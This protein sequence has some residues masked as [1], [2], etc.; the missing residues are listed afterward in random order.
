MKVR[1]IQYLHQELG[2]EVIAFESSLLDCYLA[3]SMIPDLSPTEIMEHIFFSDIW[4]TEE[5][6]PLFEYIKDTSSSHSPLILTGFDIFSSGEGLEDGS[7]F[8]FSL[9]EGLDDHYASEIKTLEEIFESSSSLEEF[10]NKINT[11]IGFHESIQAYDELASYIAQ[12]QQ[13]LRQEN[14][15]I[16][17]LVEVADQFAWS[18]ARSIEMIDNRASFDDWG[19]SLKDRDTAMAVNIQFLADELYPDK[20]IIVWAHNGHIAEKSWW[21]GSGVDNM[22][23]YLDRYFSDDLFTIGLIG[24]RSADSYWSLENQLHLY[25]KPYLFVDLSSMGKS[26]DS[27]TTPTQ[28]LTA[29]K[30]YDA[31][32]F[33]DKITSHHVLGNDG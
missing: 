20:K 2:Y 11:T 8:F 14:P 21:S 9:L 10:L 17:G 7:I 22:G 16:P 30:E 32:I 33:L 19:D 26:N 1:L 27:S 12:N 24:H 18:R 31:L 6:L 23:T 13:A 5:V 3:N 25:G 15:A 4:H 28:I 29:S